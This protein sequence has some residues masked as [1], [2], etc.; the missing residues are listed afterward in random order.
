MSEKKKSKS[1]IIG[2]VIGYF[3]FPGRF[4]DT[5]ISMNYR[6]TTKSSWPPFLKVKNEHFKIVTNFRAILGF[7]CDS[8][9][10]NP[11]EIMFI[12]CIFC[13]F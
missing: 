12:I 1:L 6:I 11:W 10:I 8:V 7:Q 13:F 2:N 4:S 5:D 3:F 9:K